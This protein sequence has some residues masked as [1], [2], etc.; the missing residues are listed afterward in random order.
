MVATQQQELQESTY[1][2]QARLQAAQALASTGSS[3]PVSESIANSPIA[4]ENAQDIQQ[5]VTTRGQ[6]PQT[7]QELLRIQTDFS[8]RDITAAEV[9]EAISGKAAEDLSAN[10][11]NGRDAVIT[12]YSK[13]QSAT[14][15]SSSR[16][17]N[18][19]GTPI[20][21]GQAQSLEQELTV[22]T[23]YGQ[24]QSLSAAD[25]LGILALE[26]TGREAER[27][28]EKDRQLQVHMA[29]A[30]GRL[31]EV[32]L[33]QASSELNQQ[34]ADTTLANTP[35][36]TASFRDTY[37]RDAYESRRGQTQEAPNAQDALTVASRDTATPEP[38]GR[39]GDVATLERTFSQ[40]ADPTKIPVSEVAP[41]LPSQQSFIESQFN[42]EG[43]GQAHV[44]NA[45]TLQP[46]TQQ[47]P[48]IN[49][50]TIDLRIPELQPA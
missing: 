38:L 3:A 17:Q 46:G 36:A 29:Q 34:N 37:M 2:R 41:T 42:V 45:N 26:V 31:S 19:D 43:N 12:A 44:A 30:Y 47:E 16:E 48:T 5:T 27:Q 21:E 35:R 49:F 1:E 40:D 20:A 14:E 10:G 13:G 32:E 23:A 15:L 18:P 11:G 4:L 25:R 39:A 24:D 33:P 7:V 22:A 50:N 6:T 8:Q 9:A 28:A